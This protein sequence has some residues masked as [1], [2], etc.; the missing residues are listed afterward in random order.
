VKKT[1]P[2]KQKKTQVMQRHSLTTSHQQTAAQT[3]LKQRPPWKNSPL[4]V[5][6]PS[7]TLYG[8]EHP[9]GQFGSAVPVLSPLN[10]LPTPKLLPEGTERETEK[11]LTQC[12]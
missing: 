9:F 2:K 10:L 3:I 6:L 12:K 4:P 7:G 5:L 8:M 1:P 11:A